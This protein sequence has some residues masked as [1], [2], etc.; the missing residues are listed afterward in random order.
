M[1]K[2][3]RNHLKTIKNWT[4]RKDFPLQAQFLFEYFF[5]LFTS[6]KGNKK[7][8]RRDS[9]PRPSPWQGDT[10]PLSHSCIY[11]I[12]QP[13][14]SYYNHKLTICQQLFYFIFYVKIIFFHAIIFA[15]NDFTP[16]TYPTFIISLLFILIAN[17]LSEHY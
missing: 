14:K 5:F 13:N 6:K 3:L 2:P 8:T 11:S 15:I 16:R 9:N 10:P 7:S 17:N 1:P 12:L 4:H